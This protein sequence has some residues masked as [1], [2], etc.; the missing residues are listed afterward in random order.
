MQAGYAWL[1]ANLLPFVIW[2]PVV[3]VRFVTGL[4]MKG[5]LTDVLPIVA[6][7]VEFALTMQHFITWPASRIMMAV[8]L[9][10]VV[11]GLCTVAAGG[12]SWVREKLMRRFL[13]RFL[14][15]AEK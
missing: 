9:V 3:H 10:T 7:P 4:R 5:L 13:S 11:G 8:T 14:G 6:S 15:S 2:L 12:S 1:I